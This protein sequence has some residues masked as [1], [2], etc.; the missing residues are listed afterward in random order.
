MRPSN[1]EVPIFEL[2]FVT[3]N[4]NSSVITNDTLGPQK[5][6]KIAVETHFIVCIEVSPPTP[7][8]FT[9]PLPT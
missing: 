3:L 1:N 8:F 7:L 2:I 6:P 4:E 5:H 9:K